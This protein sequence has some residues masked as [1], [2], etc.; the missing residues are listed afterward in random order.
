[1]LG[2]DGYVAQPELQLTK[3]T[4]ALKRQSQ[5]MSILCLE[6]S[7]RVGGNNNDTSTPHELSFT[8][9]HK[10]PPRC[11]AKLGNR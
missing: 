10:Q 2:S 6:L 8:H 3:H 5:T 11:F 4:L 1:V 7:A 9:K